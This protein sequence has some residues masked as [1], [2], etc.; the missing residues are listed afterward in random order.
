MSFLSDL[1]AGG[2]KIEDFL[3][4]IVNGASQLQLIWKGLSG[5]TLAAAAAVFYDVTKAVSA[6]ES[7]AASAASGNIPGAITLS[8][9]TIGLVKQVVTDFKAGEKTIVTDFEALNIKL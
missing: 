1:E 8:E 4:D 3:K 7:A 2:K 9:T 5:P 6:G